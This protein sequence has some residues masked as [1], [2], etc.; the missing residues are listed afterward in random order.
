MAG[1][2]AKQ[3]PYGMDGIYMELASIPPGIHLE[4]G[5]TVKTSSVVLFLLSMLFSQPI[6]LLPPVCAVFW[7]T[8]MVIV[9][10]GQGC[11]CPFTS[12]SRPT[13]ILYPGRH[14]SHIQADTLPIGDAVPLV[15]A[16]RSLPMCAVMTGPGGHLSC[17]QADAL[18]IS[19]A[20]P[21][22]Y[23]IRSLPMCA[24]MTG[25]G[26][27]QQKRSQVHITGQSTLYCLLLNLNFRR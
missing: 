21:L 26:G 10:K 13:L 9:P 3:I 15:Y 12:W 16:I 5:G 20:V 2:S 23:A 7:W 17:I 8:M 24:V 19:G 22:V 25:P 14:L 6:C 1:P 27:H 4:C 18:P 11:N